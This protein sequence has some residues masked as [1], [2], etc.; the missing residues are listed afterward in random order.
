MFCS[1]CGNKIDQ[2][3]KFCT[4]CGEKLNSAEENKLAQEKED[5]SDKS[6]SYAVADNIDL[7]EN[8]DENYIDVIKK[9]VEDIK[10]DTDVVIIYTD[11]KEF[12]E[13]AKI[14]NK[15]EIILS[16]ITGVQ[17]FSNEKVFV[18]LT[19]KRII[20]TERLIFK[21]I[22]NEKF[23]IPLKAIDKVELLDTSITI[24]YNENLCE[25][26]N[27]LTNDKKTLNLFIYKINKELEKYPEKEYIEIEKTSYN[28]TDNLEYRYIGKNNVKALGE[29]EQYIAAF[30]GITGELDDNKNREIGSYA[31]LFKFY[32]TKP[33][34]IKYLFKKPNFSLGS[35]LPMA[36]FY[37]YGMYG[38]AFLSSLIYAAFIILACTTTHYFESI[39]IGV[40]I[41]YIISNSG[42]FYRTF[43]KRV[44][45]AETEKDT[46]SRLEKFKSIHKFPY[47]YKKIL[48]IS[49]CSVIAFFIISFLIIPKAAAQDGKYIQLVKNSAFNSLPN[50]TVEE[51]IN[52]S[53]D[54]PKWEQ[55]VANDGKNYVNVYGDLFGF[56][57]IIQFRI[58]DEENG[59]RVHALEVDGKPEPVGNIAQDLY[60]IYLGKDEI[61]N[62]REY[63]E[64]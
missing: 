24:N 39:F 52:G 2:G 25:Y 20:F 35:L 16:F 28:K 12:N 26:I 47:D 34:I 15:D 53:I 44:K 55:I 56:N 32:D 22:I 48:I 60:N 5:I 29:Y 59:W 64:Y 3:A 30:L 57:V 9:Q 17:S 40:A 38:Y 33:N 49:A 58:N 18:I 7:K 50:I 1:N 37:Y 63:F 4:N 62:I 23:S 54:N 41:N 13:L 10:S 6:T 61:D 21:S 45:I 51:L 14:I 46:E 8:K 36:D 31:T 11:D 27:G 43:K 19:T 42:A